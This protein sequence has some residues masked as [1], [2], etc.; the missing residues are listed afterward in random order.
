[1]ENERVDKNMTKLCTELQWYVQALEA[2]KTQSNGYPNWFDIIKGK[3]IKNITISL[4]KFRAVH[5]FETVH[6]LLQCIFR[7]KTWINKQDSSK[8]GYLDIL[9]T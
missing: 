6:I 1:M 7:K 4:Q 2:Q 9:T 8:I 5:M 3:I